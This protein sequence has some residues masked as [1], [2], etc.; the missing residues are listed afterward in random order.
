MSIN[1]NDELQM[2]KMNMKALRRNYKVNLIRY[3]KSLID[4]LQTELE[5]LE[6]NPDYVPNGCGIVQGSAKV[7]DDYC[8]KL[9]VMDMISKEW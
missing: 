6:N 2:M 9:D 1:S 5:Q 7:I 8:V 4:T 3:T